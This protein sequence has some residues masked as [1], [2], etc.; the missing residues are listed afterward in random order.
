MRETVLSY[1]QQ[2]E[3]DKIVEILKDNK[4]FNLLISDQIFETI[5]FQ[6]FTYQLLNYTELELPYP[7]FLYNCHVSDDY[8]FKFNNEDEEKILKFLIDKTKDYNYAKKLPNYSQSILIIEE[9]ESKLQIESEISVKI[10]K[11]HKDLEIVEK[12]SNNK[13]YF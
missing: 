6:N 11:K 8:T 13:I 12:Y 10:A 2:N 7:A 1:L 5:F 9:Y 3:F 4:L